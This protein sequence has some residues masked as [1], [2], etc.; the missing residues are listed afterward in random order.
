MHVSATRAFVTELWHYRELFYFFA[1]RD[2]K[3]RYRQTLLGILWAVLQPVLTM[4][5]FT[6]LFGRIARIP[7][8]GVP[9]PVFYFSALLPWIFFS[10]TLTNTSNC[11]IGNANLLTKIYFPRVILPASAALGGLLDFL[12]GSVV[13][14]GI[15]VFYGILPRWH[16]ALWP[17]LALP[18]LLLTLGVGMFLAALNVRYRDI[19][20]AI[21]FVIQ[22]WLFV[23]PVIYPA[24]IVPAKYRL[25]LA[26]NP[27]T[28]IIEA[29]RYAI[30]PDRLMDWSVLVVSG[31]AAI[32]I[33]AWALI[34]FRK[35]EKTFADIV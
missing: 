33:F 19:K 21:P 3:I 31:T 17:L 22:L 24:S 8:D 32:A 35:T 1:W 11:L 14:V 29:F 6:I 27:L 26:F 5:V 25:W 28:G 18:L 7:S 4:V 13:L 9:Y 15:M 23:T 10:S 30:I 34:Y 12:I 16:V 20:Y 2:I